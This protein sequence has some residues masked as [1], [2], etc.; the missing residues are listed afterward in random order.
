[1]HGFVSVT[2]RLISLAFLL[3]LA[4]PKASSQDFTGLW[5]GFIYVLGNQL[6]YELAI[7][8]TDDKLEAYSL[9][10]FTIDGVENT[11]IKS[12]NVKAKKTK[13]SI[14]DDELV[15]DNYTTTA[16]KLTLY[17]ILSLEKEDSGWILSGSFF[18]RS[19]DRSSFKGTIRLQKQE[20]MLISKL[21][22][23]LER[24]AV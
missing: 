6:P 24:M 23:H 22:F 19:A 4:L 9:I 3:V 1:M 11:G 14:E 21:A 2:A 13:L 7:A 17:S 10:I 15:Y 18:T 20:N 5:S 16:K 12:M 8:K